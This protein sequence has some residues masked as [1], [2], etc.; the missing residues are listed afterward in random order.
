MNLT[1]DEQLFP[2]KA[3]CKFTQY[4]SNKFDEFGIKFW[5]ASDIKNK[6][7]L[8]GFP[9]L[10]QDETRLWKKYYDGQFSY[11][12]VTDEKIVGKTHDII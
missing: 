6:C 1:I 5:L 7:V 2:T 10:G 11:E 4:M 9:Y 12:C 3:R 8:N